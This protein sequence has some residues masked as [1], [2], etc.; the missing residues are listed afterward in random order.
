[1]AIDKDDDG[2][3]IEDADD[4]DHIDDV[5]VDNIDDREKKNIDEVCLS[6][7][8]STAAHTGPPLLFVK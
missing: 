3:D 8:C 5:T 6:A 2:V 7:N 4:D 1:M